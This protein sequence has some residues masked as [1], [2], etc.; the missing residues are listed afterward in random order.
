MIYPGAGAGDGVVGEQF[1]VMPPL[2]ASREDVDLIVDRL[3]LALE[4]P[5]L[6]SYDEREWPQRWLGATR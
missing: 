4:T 5:T 1:L 6:S 3:A 2:I